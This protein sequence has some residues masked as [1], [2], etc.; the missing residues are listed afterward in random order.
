MLLSSMIFSTI[1]LNEKT[2]I[3]SIVEGKRFYKYPPYQYHSQKDWKSILFITYSNDIVWL[4]SGLY[5]T[6]WS[7]LEKRRIFF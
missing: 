5:Q 2:L 3:Q 4:L 7:D 6:N 1:A